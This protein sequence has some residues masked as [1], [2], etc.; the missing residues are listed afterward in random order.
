MRLKAV[1]IFLDGADT[2]CTIFSVFHKSSENFKPYR[3][4]LV[5]FTGR[6]CIMYPYVLTINWLKI[7]WRIIIIFSPI[8]KPH[9]GDFKS[10]YVSFVMLQSPQFFFYELPIRWCVFHIL[11]LTHACTIM[12]KHGKLVASNF[13]EEFT[14]P[15]ALLICLASEITRR[16]IWLWDMAWAHDPVFSVQS[17]CSTVVELSIICVI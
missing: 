5:F 17:Y 1:D 4:C 2:P 8:P 14:Q 7:I 9:S 10:N 11:L 6:C 13:S 12:I 3:R 16:S 15:P